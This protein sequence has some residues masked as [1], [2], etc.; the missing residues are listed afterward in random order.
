MHELSIA[1]SIVDIAISIA[2]EHKASRIT[3]IQLQV[4]HLAGIEEESLRFC[5]ASVTRG[6]LAE[7]AVLQ[8]EKIP[9]TARCLDCQRVFPVTDYV[10]QCPACHSRTV[11]TESGRELKVAY[12]DI[13]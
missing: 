4:G 11:V 9:I 1:E 2:T 3:S 8:I 5:F 10:F 12:V 6:T 7:H 13:D